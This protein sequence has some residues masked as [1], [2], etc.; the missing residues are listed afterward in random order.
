M[1]LIASLTAAA[2]GGTLQPAAEVAFWR[3][4]KGTHGTLGLWHFDGP[5]KTRC[6][7]ASAHR[8]PTRV[9]GKVDWAREGRFSGALRIA[10]RPGAVRVDLNTPIRGCKHL[11]LEAW[12]RLDRYPSG[13]AVVAAR[14]WKRGKTGGLALV[15]DATGA[16]RLR[17]RRHD[18]QCRPMQASAPAGAVPVGRWTHLA[19]LFHWGNTAIVYV[20]G[21]EKVRQPFGAGWAEPEGLGND[22][23]P[24]RLWIGNDPT[25]KRPLP[26]SIDEVRLSANV[27]RLFPLP[28]HSWTDPQARRPRVQGRPYVPDMTDVLLYAS[29]DKTT[30]ADRAAGS[31][32]AMPQKGATLVPGVRGTGARLG[33]AFKSAGNLNLNEGTL[34]Y[35][36]APIDWNN[37][38]RWHVGVSSGPFMIYIWNVGILRPGGTPLVAWSRDRSATWF[39]GVFWPDQW[40]HVVVSWKGP[41]VRT[42]LDGRLRTERELRLGTVAQYPHW[43]PEFAVRGHNTYDELYVY[44]RMLSHDEI[45]NCYRRYREPAKLE[46][47]PA[48]AWRLAALPGVGGV[49]CWFNRPA[50][51]GAAGATH[52]RLQVTDARGKVLHRGKPQALGDPTE[53]IVEK[54]PPLADGVYTCRAD[55][56]DAQGR[57]VVSDTKPLRRKHFPWENNRIGMGDRVIPPYTPIQTDGRRLSVWGRQY[58]IG[59]SGLPDQIEVQKQPILTQ[60]IRLTGQAGGRPIHTTGWQSRVTDAKAHRVDVSAA[61]RIAGV[62]ARV[63]AWMEYDGWYQVRLHLPAAPQVRVDRLSLVMDL[64]PEA[65]TLY[66]QLSDSRTRSYFGAVPPGKGVVW[67][68]AKL[69]SAGWRWGSFVPVLH[70][71]TGDRGLWWMAESHDGWTL[72][73]DVPCVEVVRGDKAVTLRLNLIARPTRLTEARTI[74]FALLASPVKPLARGWRRIAWNWP[75]TH[76]V[77]DTCGYRYYGDSVDSY[78]LH[79]E[80]DFAALRRFLQQPAQTNPDYSWYERLAEGVRLGKPIALY[81][82]T[83]MTG[84]AMEEFKHFGQEWLHNDRW[85]PMPDYDFEGRSNYGG[86]ARWRTPEELTAS[87]VNFADSYVDCFIWYHRKLAEK[88]GLNGTWW[89]NSS[90]GTICHY[91]PGRG[92][93]WKW[94]VFTRRRLTKRLAVMGWE[95]A[96]RPWWIMNLHADFSW[97]QIGWHVEND[98]YIHGAGKTMFDHMDVAQFRALTCTKRGI[99]SQ[100]HSRIPDENDTW[101]Y[102]RAMRSIIGMCLLHDV[103]ERGLQAWRPFEGALRKRVLEILEDKVCFF[104]GRPEFIPYWR[105]ARIVHFTTPNVYASVYAL[106]RPQP[107]MDPM[108]HMRRAVI[109]LVNANDTDCVVKDF[110]IEAGALGL[111][112]IR[113]LYD[114][115]TGLSTGQEY[116][117]KTR[118][119]EWGERHSRHLML[120][121]HDYRLLVVE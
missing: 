26:G 51:P 52:V 11:C 98:F 62:Q 111:D 74:E 22:A 1:L 9:V 105:S 94:N 41:V 15:V 99:I 109:V 75:T 10:G 30:D 49:G 55:V 61:G 48:M 65:D 63:S 64:W 82:S 68:S 13:E 96:R 70:L 107:W 2:S 19:G 39:G 31:P 72:D 23:D 56:L 59:K 92:K 121:R 73:K 54:L 27:V 113:R 34:E 80:E 110:T 86:S 97:C 17:W 29:F 87:G 89:D 83:W 36:F 71:G 102:Y 21:H 100:L 12:V 32:K 8:Q 18:R 120:R 57:V 108:H 93:V 84:L 90:I 79:R 38:D 4:Y 118:R 60:P 14:D 77:H 67:H 28:D 20:N 43:A 91:V 66:A 106:G 7:D 35:W 46:K 112:T 104:S 116:N 78:A 85:H 50:S 47:L 6:L 16:L 88:V 42:Y 44:R 40:A 81:G 117:R 114:A 45:A 33:V 95:L 37:M 69:P 25:L 103:G 58:T 115:E 76:Y 101:T 119:R 24:G 3:P 53:A 5:A